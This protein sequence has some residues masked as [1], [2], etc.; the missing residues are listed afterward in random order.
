MSKDINIKEIIRDKKSEFNV[1]RFNIGRLHFEKPCKLLDAK[2]ATKKHYKL[3]KDGFSN[4]LFET[5]KTIKPEIIQSILN[6]SNESNINSK[7]GYSKWM[8]N[9]EHIFVPTFDF[10]PYSVHKDIDKELSGYFNYCYSYSKTMSMVPNIKVKRNH[11]EVA[12]NGKKKKQ[13]IEIINL[14]NYIRFVN[15][16]HAIFDRKN[17]KPIFVPL[18]LNLSINDI[19]AL[20]QE[21]LKKEYF[22][23]WIDFEGAPSTNPAKL[24]KLRSFYQELDNNERFDD[25]VVHATNIKREIV[26]NKANIES[27]A[28][29]VLSSLNGANIIGSN[30]EPIRFN[31]DGSNEPMTKEE[32]QIILEHKA[33]IFDSNS[34]F[35][36]KREASDLDVDLCE[37][38]LNRKFNTLFN[39]QLLDNE[40]HNQTEYFLEEMDLKEYIAS[41]RMMN[42]FKNG[43]LCDDFFRDKKIN[44]SVK[45]K[46]NIATDFSIPF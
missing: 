26:S 3:L 28:S 44:S 17:N 13:E 23:I 27:P 20:T 21:Y 46:T 2:N 1:K 15:E 9:Y 34:Y 4:T 29:D 43:R 32:K 11:Y 31:P 19:E 30:R 36:L 38:L 33:R 8:E 5:T 14:D 12:E 22:N 35:Y 6:E 42:T 40:F 37:Q 24:A 39:A 16:S 45:N 25:V 7:F 18:S 10:N 41:K